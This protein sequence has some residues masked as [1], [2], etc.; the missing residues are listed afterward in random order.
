MALTGGGAGGFANTVNPTGTGTGLNY[1]GNHA[2][3]YSGMA[4]SGGGA[5]TTFLQFTTGNSYFVGVMEPQYS[6]ESGN[7]VKFATE[8]NGEAV[9][10]VN[11]SS[12]T[13]VQY[14]GAQLIIP[15][16]TEV[17]VVITNLSGGSSVVGVAMSGRVYA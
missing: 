15:P 12:S 10:A 3:A 4:G 13:A 2:Y 6:S 7:D 8:M 5:A 16:Y 1:V 17:K 14:P 9:L 11:L